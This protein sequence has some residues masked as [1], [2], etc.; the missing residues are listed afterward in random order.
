MNDPATTP[1]RKNKTIANH[2]ILEIK[3]VILTCS[4]KNK[5]EIILKITEEAKYVRFF[6]FLTRDVRDI[7]K[8]LHALLHTSKKHIEDSK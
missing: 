6:H 2:V 3:Q 7:Y 5:P 1:A 8:M 4:R